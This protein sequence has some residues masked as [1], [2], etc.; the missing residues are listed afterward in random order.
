MLEVISRNGNFLINIGPRADG[1]IPEPQVA[2]LKAMGKWLKINA[3]AIYGSRYWKV[4]E[5]V[6]EHLV[7]TTNGK[8]LYAIKLKQPENPFTI[9]GTAGW[10]ADQVKNVSLLGSYAE[11]TWK[12]TDKG[13]RITP[14]S[15]LGQSLHAW[16]FEIQTSTEQHHPNVIV[17]D[18]DKALKGTKKVNLEGNHF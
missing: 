10:D 4:S 11:V 5:Q 12:M 16:S 8:K 15:N 1:T 7:F 14:P 3:K 9:T 13:L 17:L 2:R 6:D 18:V